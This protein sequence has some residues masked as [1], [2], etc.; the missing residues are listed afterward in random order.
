[1]DVRKCLQL[2]CLCVPVPSVWMQCWC[3]EWLRQLAL[4]PRVLF[5]FSIC[6]SQKS[7]SPSLPF[8]DLG[9]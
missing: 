8:R 9:V 1:M 5:C 2:S 4:D 7:I 6:D 3:A